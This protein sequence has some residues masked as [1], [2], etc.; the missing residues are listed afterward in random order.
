MI[1]RFIGHNP[2]GS[3]DYQYI[4]QRHSSQTTLFLASWPE[5]MYFLRLGMNPKGKLS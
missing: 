4:V 5:S 2:T 3:N 1:F